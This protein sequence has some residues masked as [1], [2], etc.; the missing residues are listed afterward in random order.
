[1]F[2]NTFNFY[3]HHISIYLNCQIYHQTC[4]LYIIKDYISRFIIRNGSVILF[5]LLFLKLL[6]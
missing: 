4:S 6:L 1:M 2:Q 5:L 3:L